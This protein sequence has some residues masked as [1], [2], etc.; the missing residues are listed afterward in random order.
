MTAHQINAG[1]IAAEQ[2]SS[3][4]RLCR[5]RDGLGVMNL[6]RKVDQYETDMRTLQGSGDAAAAVGAGRLL[7]KGMV[8]LAA[9]VAEGP[10]QMARK[11]RALQPARVEASGLPE[12]AVRMI[13]AGLQAER[14]LLARI[15]SSR[16]AEGGLHPDAAAFYV[17]FAKAETLA[18]VLRQHAG[19]LHDHDYLISKG[20]TESAKRLAEMTVLDVLRPASRTAMSYNEVGLKLALIEAPEGGTPLLRAMLGAVSA[21]ER[22]D[23]G[24]GTTACVVN[25]SQGT[26]FPGEEER[27]KQYDALGPMDVISLIDKAEAHWRDLA[28]VR[29]RGSQ[30]EIATG[31]FYALVDF[32]LRAAATAARNRSEA[33]RKLEFIVDLMHEIGTDVESYPSVMLNAALA[34]ECENWGIPFI[35]VNE[36]VPSTRH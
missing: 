16:G 1:T 5:R 14:A 10:R 13:A 28:S 25:K 22:R 33:E 20:R 15:A 6:A 7:Q 21:I 12:V 2:A 9:A 30:S 35:D 26:V 36:R 31:C 11:E 32:G 17:E 23:W 3:Y 29:R 8:L 4:A 24:L 18:E 19:L 34:L 27:C